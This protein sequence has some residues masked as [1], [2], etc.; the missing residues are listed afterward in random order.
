MAL[1]YMAPLFT[2]ISFLLLLLLDYP[3]LYGFLSCPFFALDFRQ[4]LLSFLSFHVLHLDFYVCSLHLLLIF[5][6]FLVFLSPI[7][8]LRC[9]W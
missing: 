9:E 6:P 1:R 2:L 3:C 4:V 7:P 8:A 5:L